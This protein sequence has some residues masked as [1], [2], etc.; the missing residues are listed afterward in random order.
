MRAN[1]TSPAHNIAQKRTSLRECPRCVAGSSLPNATN[2]DSRNSWYKSLIIYTMAPACEVSV[3]GSPRPPPTLPLSLLPSPPPT[4]I[5]AAVATVTSSTKSAAYK[6]AILPPPYSRMIRSV[7]PGMSFTYV[8][9]SSDVTVFSLQ[10]GRVVR[11]GV[12]NE[13]NIDQTTPERY[14][15]PEATGMPLHIHG[16][17]TV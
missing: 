7:S 13:Y 11:G 9:S 12:G 15:K 17:S 4:S 5:T 14:R 2:A 1:L 3:A 8:S 16:L 6:P 10:L